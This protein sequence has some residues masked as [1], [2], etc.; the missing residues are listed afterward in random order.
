MTLETEKAYRY[1]RLIS[2]AERN[3][4]GD[5][6]DVSYVLPPTGFHPARLVSAKSPSYQLSA[7]EVLSGKG[8]EQRS[9][10]NRFLPV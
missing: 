8:P 2:W 5:V 7:R 6:S 1:W 9:N 3:P 10:P 4:R